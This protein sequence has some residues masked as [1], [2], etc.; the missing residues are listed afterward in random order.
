MRNAGY[1]SKKNSKADFF[2][3]KNTIHKYEVF[4]IKSFDGK[5]ITDSFIC[6]DTYDDMFVRRKVLLEDPEVI[7]VWFQK[8]EKKP[9]KTEKK[10]RAFK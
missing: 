6:H 10:T 8:E 5:E 9:K 1:Y 3:R 2:K 7:K 4:V